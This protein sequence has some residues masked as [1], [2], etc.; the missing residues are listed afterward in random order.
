MKLG[1]ILF[2]QWEII[3]DSDDE[4]VPYSNDTSDDE[5]DDKNEVDQ[6]Q[7][8]ETIKSL[9]TETTNLPAEEISKYL[10]NETKMDKR[11]TRFKE[12]TKLSPDQVIRYQ[13]LGE[14]LW[15]SSKK[16]PEAKDIPDCEFCGAPRIFEFQI[17]PQMLN[18][19]G[20]DGSSQESNLAAEGI[21]WGVLCIYTCSS[22]CNEG[23]AYKQEFLWKQNIE[24]N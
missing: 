16:I 8:I 21:D 1:V 23:S 13:R 5:E 3:M 7:D 18:N 12:T 22:S 15:I 10:G 2:P 9:N 4:Q 19:L 20:L 6:E 24:E 11:Y 14:P 17:M